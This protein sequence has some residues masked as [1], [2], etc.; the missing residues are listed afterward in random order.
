MDNKLKARTVAK[1]GSLCFKDKKF[2]EALAK[3]DEAIDLDSQFTGYYYNRGLTYF[4]LKNYESAI[5]DFDLVIASD[6]YCPDAYIIKGYCLILIGRFKD[7]FKY[8]KSLQMDLLDVLNLYPIKDI[9][10][11]IPFMLDD[12]DDFSNQVLSVHDILKSND[13]FK[14]YQKIYLESL[15]I[16]SSLR[17]DCEFEEKGIAHYTQKRVA[18]ELLFKNSNIRLCSVVNTNDPK[19]GKILLPFL[20]IGET[21]VNKEYQAFLTCFTFNHNCLNQFR[22]YGKEDN[23]EA[24]GI[25]IVLNNNF[26][27]PIKDLLLNSKNT[28]RNN[29]N[30]AP[31]HECYLYRCI[32]MD[33]DTN[34]VISIGHKEDYTF[35]RDKLEDIKAEELNANLIEEVNGCI[36]SYRNYIDKKR[37]IIIEKLNNIKEMSKGENLDKRVICE[38][39]L[40]LRYLIKHVAFKEEQE[41]RVIVVRKLSMDKD[42]IKMREDHN[43]MYI[44]LKDIRTEVYS[45]CFGPKASGF[46]LFKDK[47]QYYDL[48]NNITYN[49]CEHPFA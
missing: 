39:L 9:E 20:N 5:D 48:A 25:S 44:D 47:L 16:I 10:S 27:S 15:E 46:E 43:G 17:V 29:K 11:L 12:K 7:A 31:Q 42:I 3:Y 18:E 26:F 37:E 41:C 22:L 8:F 40:K 2:N 1:H 32:Y 4:A 6:D 33:P 38:L 28:G 36:S 24:T 13:N 45:V 35:Y 49:K 23:K 21:D 19:E 34:Q 14:I 30:R